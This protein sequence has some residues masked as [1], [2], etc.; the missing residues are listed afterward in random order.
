MVADE[1]YL[2]AGYDAVGAAY[3]DREGYLRDGL[4]LD[5]DLLARLRD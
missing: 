5:D 3:G 4:G 1:E 2:Q